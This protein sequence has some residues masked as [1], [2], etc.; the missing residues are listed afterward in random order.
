[1][2]CAATSVAS[3]CCGVASRRCR[4]AKQSLVVSADRSPEPELPGCGRRTRGVQRPAP[5]QRE[6]CKEP[7]L[8]RRGAATGGVGFPAA[9]QERMRGTSAAGPRTPPRSRQQR[10][11]GIEAG[12]PGLQARFTRAR[13]GESRTRYKTGKQQADHRQGLGLRWSSV[14]LAHVSHKRPHTCFTATLSFHT[15]RHVS[16]SAGLI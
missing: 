10:V 3:D 6:A 9:P 8:R 7:P 5:N 16:Y 1:M 2:A 4:R 15:C 14:I 12:W 11:R 13:F